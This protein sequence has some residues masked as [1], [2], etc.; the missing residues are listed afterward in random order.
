MGLP[1]KGYEKTL[2][3]LKYY[4]EHPEIGEKVILLGGGFA[5]VECAVGLAMEGKT[6]VRHFQS[7]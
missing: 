1:V 2:P 7:S 4:D 3:I 5:G 6:P